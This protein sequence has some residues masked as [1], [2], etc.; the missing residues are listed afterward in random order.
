[1]HVYGDKPEKKMLT[2]IIKGFQIKKLQTEMKGVWRISFSHFSFHLQPTV[3]DTEELDDH[4]VKE[5]LRKILKRL[6]K[7][8]CSKEVSLLEAAPVLWQR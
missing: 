7:L 4:A 3:N 8:K 5:K 6:G 2:S 1:M